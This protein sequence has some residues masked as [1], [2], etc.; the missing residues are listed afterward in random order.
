MLVSYRTMTTFLLLLNILSP[1]DAI[2]YTTSSQRTSLSFA[3]SVHIKH[4]RALSFPTLP[5]L[6]LESKV[7]SYTYFPSPDWIIDFH[8]FHTL[9]P[10]LSATSTLLTFYAEIIMKATITKDEIAERSLFRLG[11]LTLEIQS[12]L[13]A[14][15]WSEIIAFATWMQGNTVRGFTGVYQV[16]FVYRP[17][18]KLV[19]MSLWAGLLR[20]G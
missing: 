4:S 8:A 3:P 20:W 6:F 13:G 1:N 10:S 18:G 15:P 14:V 11:E 12:A 16:N 9:L 7:G 2:A 17:T 19:T 5:V